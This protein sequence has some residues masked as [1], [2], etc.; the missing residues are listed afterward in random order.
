MPDTSPILS[1]PYI[2]PS[3]AQ[4]HVTH[5]EA[6]RHLDAIV[7]LVVISSDQIVPPVNPIPGDRYIVGAA[8]SGA[9]FG[10]DGMIAVA[11][12]NGWAFY[13]AHSGWRADDLSRNRQIRFDGT[14][15]VAIPQGL[16]GQTQLGI[17][18]VADGD[19][20]LAV[21]GAATLLTHDGA[22]HQLKINKAMPQA[23]ASLLFQTDWSGRAELGLAGTEDFS[24]KV[25]PD[26]AL[27]TTALALDRHTGA[28]RVPG[29]PA[30]S[31]SGTGGWTTVTT[32]QTDL[33]FDTVQVNRGGHYNATTARFTA[34]VDGFY[35]FLING[36]LGDTTDATICF[37]I[38]GTPQ[39]AQMQ[40][41]RGDVPLSFQAVFA[42]ATGDT[43]SC[44]TGDLSGTLTYLQSQTTLSGWLIS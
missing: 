32:A 13:G 38:N 8:A 44:R 4:K 23:T 41:V 17:G 43:V 18:T 7:Q 34:P 29:N 10:Q 24:I 37:A 12:G 33:V 11:E 26:G 19:N 42:L 5:N 31:A 16:E 3:Q 2:L 9:W 20:R 22:G 35:A 1:L 14:D 30:F 39:L 28:M 36:C 40:I 21:A 15:W 27:F 25:S 6:L